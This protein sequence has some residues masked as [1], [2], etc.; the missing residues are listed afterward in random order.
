MVTIF[1]V[2]LALLGLIIQQVPFWVHN[3]VYTI[4]WAFKSTVAWAYPWQIGISGDRSRKLYL[5]L[6]MGFYYAA[7]VKNHLFRIYSLKPQSLPFPSQNIPH[8]QL[9][10]F[11]LS[12]IFLRFIYLREKK[13]VHKCGGGGG[14]QWGGWEEQREREN[15]KQTLH[16]REEPDTGLQQIIDLMISALFL[17]KP[18]SSRAYHWNP[19]I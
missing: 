4:C 10:D 13:I 12:F 15:L 8:P 5:K 16:S 2:L 3:R 7:S 14:G 9:L 18:L 11:Y 17:C 1:K 19:R 6:P